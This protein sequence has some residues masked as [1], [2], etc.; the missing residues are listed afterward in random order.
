MYA[1]R[2]EEAVDDLSQAF[3]IRFGTAEAESEIARPIVELLREHPPANRR[4]ITAAI[5]LVAI[6]THQIQWPGLVRQAGSVITLHPSPRLLTGGFRL[7]RRASIALTDPREGS[8]SERTAYSL[9]RLS[10]ILRALEPHE[11]P[12]DGEPLTRR[13]GYVDSVDRCPRRGGRR[14]RTGP[15]RLARPEESKFG[16]Q[17]APHDTKLSSREPPKRHS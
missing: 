13:G 3:T 7:L 2:Y 12:T 15:G 4:S 9:S 11:S 16:H 1:R 10:P 6:L 14:G 5:R 17:R 8:D